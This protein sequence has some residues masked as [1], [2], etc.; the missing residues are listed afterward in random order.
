MASRY[1]DEEMVGFGS[2]GGD[3]PMDPAAMDLLFEEMMTDDST[4]PPLPVPAPP[5]AQLVAPLPL[6]LG[7][8]PLPHRRPREEVVA[9]DR[10]TR[11]RRRRTGPP[12]QVN[13]Q[14]RHSRGN[15][16]NRPPPAIRPIPRRQAPRRS[17]VLWCANQHRVEYDHHCTGHPPRSHSSCSIAFP[18][19]PHT[20]HGH[21]NYSLAQAEQY[22][23]ATRIRVLDLLDLGYSV[24][25]V[26]SPRGIRALLRDRHFEDDISNESIVMRC[27]GMWLLAPGHDVNLRI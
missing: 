18:W 23:D 19:L 1:P 16:S 24:L 13:G 17:T 20:C 9:N 15:T 6:S 11:R 14:N 26:G 10:P 27:M 12:P 7:Q 21:L 3:S 25:S 5:A 22:L 4:P 8:G 2:S